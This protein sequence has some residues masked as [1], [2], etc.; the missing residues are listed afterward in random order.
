MNNVQLHTML[1]AVV[2][3]VGCSESHVT[4]PRPAEG[5]YSLTAST[6]YF[7]YQTDEDGGSCVRLD[8]LADDDGGSP[9]RVTSN[10][11]MNHSFA[12]K[13]G[14]ISPRLPMVVSAPRR[15]CS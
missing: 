12:A 3:A 1:F 13:P 5:C 11:T 14:S 7:V 10:S 9:L 2:T 4:P 8:L 6:T 15:W